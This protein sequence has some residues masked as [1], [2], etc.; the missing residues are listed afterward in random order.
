M[1]T[2]ELLVEKAEVNGAFNGIVR[3]RVEH[4]PAGILLGEAFEIAGHL[5]RFQSVTGLE[6]FGAEH[7]AVD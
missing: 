7:E 1:F 4:E 6:R 2:G 3:L 5:V